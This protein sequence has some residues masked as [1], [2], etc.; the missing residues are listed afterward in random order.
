[1]LLLLCA[2]RTAC[3]PVRHARARSL[4]AAPLSLLFLLLLLTSP[5][6]AVKVSVFTNVTAPDYVFPEVNFESQFYISSLH[7]KPSLGI[8]ISGGNGGWRAAALGYGWLRAMHLVRE[9]MML[10]GH[11]WWEVGWH[12]EALLPALLPRDVSRLLCSVAADE[13]H[14]Q[15]S[16]HFLHVSRCL[17]D[18]TLCLYLSTPQPLFCALF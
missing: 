18:C 4:P 3:A 9:G 13:H 16:V 14:H 7:A 1:M 11:V 5:A 15:G 10:L 12:C 8:A 2:S 17:G 6:A